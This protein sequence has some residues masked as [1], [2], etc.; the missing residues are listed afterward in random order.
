MAHYSIFESLKVIFRNHWL[1]KV[2]ISKIMK[3]HFKIIQLQNNSYIKSATTTTV[4][5]YC[6]SEANTFS[7]NGSLVRSI[8][9]SLY[10]TR[11]P[12]FTELMDFFL[13]L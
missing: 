4:A 3:T 11:E 2:S 10:S 8:P 12:R 1:K 13:F 7:E 5:A 6:N 9:C